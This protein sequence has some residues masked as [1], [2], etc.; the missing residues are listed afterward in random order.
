MTLAERLISLGAS[1]GALG[2]LIALVGL[3]IGMC[4][5]IARGLER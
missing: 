4:G 3:A 2:F 1:I 5:V